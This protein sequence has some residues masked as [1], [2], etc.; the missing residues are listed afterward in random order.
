MSVSPASS[1][2]SL[3][4]RHS[5]PILPNEVT[6]EQK[7]PPEF[8]IEQRIELLTSAYEARRYRDAKEH[9][10]YLIEKKSLNYDILVTLMRATH[11]NGDFIELKSI[12][13]IATTSDSLNRIN[14]KN[15]FVMRLFRGLAKELGHE[16][17]ASE[18]VKKTRE[19][20]W[21][22]KET[23]KI[24]ENK[25]ENQRESRKTTSHNR[26]NSNP[27]SNR[28]KKEERNTGGD[29]LKERIIELFPTS[30]A[31]HPK[32]PMPAGGAS[33]EQ[34]RHGINRCKSLTEAVSFLEEKRLKITAS[35]LLQ[36][37]ICA[38]GT[39][40]FELAAYLF[41]EGKVAGL[42]HPKPH[43][44]A[45]IQCAY[46][47]Q[48]Y[49]RATEELEN[50]INTG[51]KIHPDLIIN[52]MMTA[53]K[54][55]DFKEVE[56]LF[57]KAEE[58]GIVNDLLCG[59]FLF[60]AE[61]LKHPEV[62]KRGVDF[63]ENKDIR[64]SGSYLS[65]LIKL[66][67]SHGDPKILKDLER[68]GKIR[69][70]FDLRHQAWVDKE[71]RM[72]QIIKS[73]EE[74]RKN[75]RQKPEQDSKTTSTTRSSNRQANTQSA[76]TP[77]NTQS[78]RPVSSDI[79]TNT[80]PV[81]SREDLYAMIDACDCLETAIDL[82][83]NLELD[84]VIFD[85]LIQYA[86]RTGT[87]E[88]IADLWAQAEI[89]SLE[90]QDSSRMALVHSAYAARQYTYAREH[91]IYLKEKKSL[92]P[93]ELTTLMESTGKNGDFKELQEL[94]CLGEKTAIV[95]ESHENALLLHRL[96]LKNDAV[97]YGGVDFLQNKEIPLDATDLYELMEFFAKQR[98][99]PLVK[100][101]FGIGKERELL[102]NP[103]RTLYLFYGRDH[104]HPEVLKEGTDFLANCEQLDAK[105]LNELW[106]FASDARA[107]EALKGLMESAKAKNLVTDSLR[108]KFLFEAIDLGHLEVIND[109]VG[110]LAD[111][112]IVLFDIQVHRLMLAAYKCKN[113]K[114]LKELFEI[115][116]TRKFINPSGEDAIFFFGCAEKLG[117]GEEAR[118]VIGKKARERREMEQRQSQLDLAR[119]K[120]E[121][122]GAG[123][124]N[125]PQL[126]RALAGAAEERPEKRARH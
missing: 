54:N 60:C 41:D 101:L 22:E 18:I 39:G 51:L 4:Q 38:G 66:A 21:R 99:F 1:P 98:H 2:E 88:Q 108:K 57:E 67:I 29:P 84:G 96:R 53:S 34:I 76:N 78:A 10:D 16:R 71:M 26:L 40:S 52:L 115:G 13:Q 15:K 120:K 65:T 45:F 80:Q 117:H 17:E 5:I 86:A 9:L 56:K 59:T 123:A 31:S 73:R 92:P 102:T 110:F 97:S 24:V 105:Q 11:K 47:S 14:A 20:Q 36:L 91:L 64:L 44:I 33:M 95:T 114:V 116:T 103:H 68:V 43:Y 100:N 6:E 58:L 50:L 7:Q 28:V 55:G 85:K 12:F 125:T 49:E 113:F 118:Q 48:N 8:T 62:L 112:D 69:G 19:N 81:R 72:M 82:T 25:R 94:L 106:S 109:G 32:N 35:I 77:T 27:R 23:S 3:Y 107:F 111:E 104:D 122:A 70:V 79:P 30:N 93:A 87:F 37:I 119:R 42:V 46:A 126:K 121:Q 90:V 74:T 124:V 61:Q 75:Q 63:L 89:R 83:A